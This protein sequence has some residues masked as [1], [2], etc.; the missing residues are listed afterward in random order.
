MCYVMDLQTNK[1]RGKGDNLSKKIN[2]KNKKMNKYILEIKPHLQYIC[3]LKLKHLNID[4]SELS[5]A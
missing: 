3:D 1:K 5:S 4:H 2:K